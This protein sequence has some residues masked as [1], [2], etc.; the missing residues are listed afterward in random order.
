MIV[1]G[2]AINKISIMIGLEEQ[3]ANKKQRPLNAYT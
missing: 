1:F 2:M 3:Q